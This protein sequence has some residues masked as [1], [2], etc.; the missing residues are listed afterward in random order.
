[1]KTIKEFKT[2]TKENYQVIIK[3]ENRGTLIT[4]YF[5]EVFGHPRQVLEV[6][7]YEIHKGVFSFA[8]YN[9]VQFLI[10]A[11]NLE[12][13]I[14][15]AKNRLDDIFINGYPNRNEFFVVSGYRY[16]NENFKKSYDLSFME[17]THLY[18]QFTPSTYKLK[19]GDLLEY[20]TD[21]DGWGFWYAVDESGKRIS[22]RLKG[23]IFIG[24]LS[25]GVIKRY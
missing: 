9:I 4:P 19:I 22:N 17:N 24:Y 21:G 11:D 10:K 1:M 16:D 6:N 20:D 13:A 7:F 23:G 14:Q 12:T 5:H 2:V 15:M 8:K 3:E 25:D 18:N